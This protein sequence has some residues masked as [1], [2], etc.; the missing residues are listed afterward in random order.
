[1]VL[2]DGDLS[3]SAPSLL[4]RKICGSSDSSQTPRLWDKHRCLWVCSTASTLY[5]VIE[6]E[7][8]VKSEESSTKPRL[9]AFSGNG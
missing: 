4:R 7:L 1:M 5:I 3:R 2:K 9:P 8:K 6:K